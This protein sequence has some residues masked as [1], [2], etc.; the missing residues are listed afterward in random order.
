MLFLILH[1]LSYL[2]HFFRIH[3]IKLNGKPDLY[4][5]YSARREALLSNFETF[6]V[7]IVIGY[8]AKHLLEMNIETF[9]EEGI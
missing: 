5:V 6:M 8:T 2:V 3:D 9:H 1:V 7:C 4:G